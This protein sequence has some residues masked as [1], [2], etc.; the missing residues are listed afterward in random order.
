[1]GNP[2]GISKGS[3]K[4]GKPVLCLSALSIPRRFQRLLVAPASR[5]TIISDDKC[6]YRYK[7]SAKKFSQGKAILKIVEHVHFDFQPTHRLA[8]PVGSIPAE[9]LAIACACSFS[10]VSRL[11]GSEL[12]S[13]RVAH[14]RRT[15]A[16]R[17]RAGSI[18]WRRLRRNVSLPGPISQGATG[19]DRG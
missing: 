5:E 8:V 14:G 6:V 19:L 2:G 3:G 10:A 15:G 13:H 16:A 4:G 9:R 17:S 12:L 1:M 11:V 7:Q 18:S